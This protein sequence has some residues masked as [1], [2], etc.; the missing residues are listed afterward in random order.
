MLWKK[1]NGQ[2]IETNDLDATVLHC[3]DIGW[4]MV[5]GEVPETEEYTETYIPPDKPKEKKSKKSKK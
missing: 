5:D 1:P 4:E 2:T 3:I